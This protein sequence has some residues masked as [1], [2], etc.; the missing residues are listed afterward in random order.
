MISGAGSLKKLN[1]H[2]TPTNTYQNEKRND[3]NKIK[4]R[5]GEIT[6]T[7]KI[8]TFIKEYYEKLYAN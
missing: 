4:K 5:G 1:N 6:N 3:R 8:K 2:K 7:T